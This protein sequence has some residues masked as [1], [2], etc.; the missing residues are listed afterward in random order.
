MNK[1]IN[2]Y[3]KIIIP[4]VLAITIISNILVIWGFYIK[5]QGLNIEKY[6]ENYPSRV[7]VLIIG[8]IIF[9]AVESI[10]VV[11]IAKEEK[12]LNNKFSNIIYRKEGK[13]WKRK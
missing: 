13:G 5:S 3:I 8:L 1:Y 12:K 10:A 7:I 4:I 6:L 2:K 9:I 11:F